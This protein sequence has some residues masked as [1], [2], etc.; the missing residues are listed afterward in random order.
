MQIRKAAADALYTELPNGVLL[1]QDWSRP[2]KD[3]K[4]VV[5]GLTRPNLE[6]A[7]MA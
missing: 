2:A 6:P 4:E 1:V 5:T 3:L 7:G